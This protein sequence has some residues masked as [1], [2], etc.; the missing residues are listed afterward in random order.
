MVAHFIKSD[1]DRADYMNVSYAAAKASIANATVAQQ[2]KTEKII[3]TIISN[4]LKSMDMLGG[5]TERAQIE[6]QLED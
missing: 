4:S 1:E 3:H 5:D 6:G 2:Q